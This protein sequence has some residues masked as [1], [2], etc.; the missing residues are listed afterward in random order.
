MGENNRLNGFFQSLG[1]ALEDGKRIAQEVQQEWEAENLET[2]ATCE[3]RI[4]ELA[5]QCEDYCQEYYSMSREEVEEITE[6]EYGNLPEPESWAQYTEMQEALPYHGANM[7]R[8]DIQDLNITT[9]DERKS[10]AWN[11]ARAL[12]N[13]VNAMQISLDDYN[14]Q[15][16]EN[17][18]KY[19]A[20]TAI[21]GYLEKY[22]NKEADVINILG[23]EAEE[24]YAQDGTLPQDVL[25]RIDTLKYAYLLKS[26]LEELD[27]EK[28]KQK[29]TY[30]D[31]ENPGYLLSSAESDVFK[32]HKIEAKEK[33]QGISDIF[34]RVQQRH[35]LVQNLMADEIK[36]Q[37]EKP[38]KLQLPS[39]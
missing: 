1:K 3:Q 20:Q 26:V 12:E 27:T 37:V 9:D 2:L 28:E 22:K 25:D 8:L 19:E 11:K 16:Q 30:L 38:T 17:V 5:Q 29:Q 15:C 10:E 21:T 23:A 18:M 36:A 39:A 14:K 33:W 24:Q 34:E 7:L 35:D 13:L 4:E 31:A 32:K 6:D